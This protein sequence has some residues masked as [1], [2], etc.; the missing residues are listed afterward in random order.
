MVVTVNGDERVTYSQKAT[1]I[2]AYAGSDIITLAASSSIGEFYHTE[3]KEDNFSIWKSEFEIHKDADVSLRLPEISFLGISF[4]ILNDLKSRVG[5]LG[6]YTTFH[7][8]FSLIYLPSIDVS[9]KFGAGR[10]AQFG[11]NINRDYLWKIIDSPS[12]AVELFQNAEFKT[13]LLVN[14][15]PSYASGEMVGIVENFI[16]TLSEGY[17]TKLYVHAKI[18]DLIRLSIERLS[19]QVSSQSIQLTDQEILAINKSYL[20]LIKNLS[21]HISLDQAASNFGIKRNILSKGYKS[22]YGMDLSEVIFKERMQLAYHLLK[23]DKKSVK[24]VSKLTGYGSQ[25]NLSNAFKKYFGYPPKV[26]SKS[27][28]TS[29]LNDF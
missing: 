10:Y 28:K 9:Y 25:Q 21:Q 1:E 2:N 17:L 8:Q 13:P 16:S 27:G 20:F 11:V 26:L 15:R 19:G 14:N 24:E 4:S 3:I 6:E 23:H 12:L 22:L 18:L 5:G 29:S 7:K